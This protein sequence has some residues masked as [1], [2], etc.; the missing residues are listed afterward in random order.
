VVYTTTPV[1]G[2][3][4]Y[5]WFVPAGAVIASG[6][7][8]TSITVNFGAAAVSGNITVAAAN[9]CGNGPASTFPVTVNPLPAAAGTI[10]GPATVCAGSTYVYTVPT[11]ANATSY[12]WT[13]PVGATGTSTT[14]SIS[15][16]F[17]NPPASGVITVKG[18]NACGSGTTS[19]N[20]TVT[21]NPV[22]VAVVTQVGNVLTCTPAG[23][24]Y[25]WYYE[26]TAI[27][28]ATS[29]S[30]TVI[31]NT[32]YYWCVVTVNGC[33]SAI[34]NKVWVEVVGTHELAADAGFTIY[35]VP[36]NGKFTASVRY[37]VDDT[38]TIMVYN[39]VGEKL[40]ELKDVTTVGGKLDVNI[41]IRPVSGGMYSVVFVNSEH[42]VV[43]KIIVK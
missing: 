27:S 21:I 32:G 31:N 12:V 15:V 7:G 35:P 41:D 42:R 9:V 28:G 23:G 16:T 22:P 14:S 30:Y 11:I 36:N 10:T 17:T 37:P 18:T 13:L 8:S 19:P 20:F 4:S 2:A 29:Q 38:F 40:Y 5:S 25:Q 26:G 39:M 3:T 34:S 24:S 33:S 43:K 6:A 1:T